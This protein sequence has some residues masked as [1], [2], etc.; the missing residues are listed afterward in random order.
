MFSLKYQQRERHPHERFNPL[1]LTGAAAHSEAV[2]SRRT[3]ITAPTNH[4][5]FAA[6]L[7]A[8][9]VALPAEGTLRVALTR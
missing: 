6:A 8:H 9:P 1:R 2:G 7:T 4:V 5:G 3:L